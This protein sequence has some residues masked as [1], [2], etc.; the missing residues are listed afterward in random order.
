MAAGPPPSRITNEVIF[1]HEQTIASL[2]VNLV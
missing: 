1:T 2:M